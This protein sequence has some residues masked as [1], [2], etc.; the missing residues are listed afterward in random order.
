MTL[1]WR[2]LTMTGMNTQTNTFE[3]AGNGFK[4]DFEE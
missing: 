1:A 2:Q 4:V 3:N